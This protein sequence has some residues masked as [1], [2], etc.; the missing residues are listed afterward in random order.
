MDY[1]FYVAVKFVCYVAWC[2]LGLRIW[3][4]EAA[5]LLRVSGFGLLRLAIGVVA[6][7]SIFFFVPVRA[8]EL[9]WKYIAVY[10][11]V[12]MLEWFILAL[13]IRQKPWAAQVPRLLLWCL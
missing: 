13:F 12:R 8:D 5:T 4:L 1:L 11:P 6:G 2:W 10:T 9:L 3:R 7:I